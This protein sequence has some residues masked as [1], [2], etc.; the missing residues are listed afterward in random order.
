MGT[1]MRNLRIAIQ[2]AL[3]VA[4]I[5]TTG[6]ND[7]RMSFDSSSRPGNALEIQPFAVLSIDPND[8]WLTELL[9][10]SV[11]ITDDKLSK[12]ARLMSEKYGID[13][14]RRAVAVYG[15]SE[16]G[17]A[18]PLLYLPVKDYGRFLDE[19]GRQF[20]VKQAIASSIT[21]G[22]DRLIVMQVGEYAVIGTSL[23]GIEK[24]P[25]RPEDL[26][27]DLPEGYDLVFQ[28]RT[29]MTKKVCSEQM[30]Q[31]IK[32][33]LGP[34]LSELMLKSKSVTYALRSRDDKSL[35]FFADFE[36][37]SGEG[38]GLQDKVADLVSLRQGWTLTEPEQSALLKIN[39]SFAGA[40]TEVTFTNVRNSLASIYDSIPKSA[41]KKFAFDGSRGQSTLFESS[42]QGVSI[43]EGGAPASGSSGSS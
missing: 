43:R 8:V 18:H 32:S 2:F 13:V 38:D 36:P 25:E 15:L 31:S 7:M 34:N 23:K 1:H 33:L 28:C 9:L 42:G 5:Q 40:Q 3:A 4:I 29:G 22:R 17:A 12:V 30:V 11:N 26:L 6:C 10:P 19:L 24:G 16:L 35:E 27:G 21:I 20:R 14:S 39:G 41:P 37:L